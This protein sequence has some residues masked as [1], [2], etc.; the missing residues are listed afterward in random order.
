M[1]WFSSWPQI[2]AS[3][4]VARIEN[5]LAARARTLRNRFSAKAAASKAGPRLAEVA[6][7]VSVN[8]LAVMDVR[9]F[10]A[11]SRRHLQLHREQWGPAAQGPASSPLCHRRANR[12]DEN[13]G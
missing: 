3:R 6:G 9:I 13:S 5:S 4:P 8:G 10:P 12:H 2:L 1:R 11:S 7:S